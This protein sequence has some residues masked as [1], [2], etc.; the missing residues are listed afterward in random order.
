MPPSSQIIDKMILMLRAG[1]DEYGK[2]E[3]ALLLVSQLC[4]VV[5]M[6]GLDLN[7]PLVAVGAAILKNYEAH[8]GEVE[9]PT[10]VEN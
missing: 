6:G 1:M 9:M 2:D 8:H 7:M 4:A 3:Y 10:M 5:V